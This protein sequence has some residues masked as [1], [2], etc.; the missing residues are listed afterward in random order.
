M[1]A[2]FIVGTGWIDTEIIWNFSLITVAA[3][4][5]PNLIAIFLLSKE[6]RTLQD[7]YTQER[8]N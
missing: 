2:F 1:S 6:M 4:A 3:A 7:N 8:E 5:L